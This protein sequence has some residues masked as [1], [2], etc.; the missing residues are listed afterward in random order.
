MTK[1]WSEMSL[2]SEFRKPYNHINCLSAAS[3]ISDFFYLRDQRLPFPWRHSTDQMKT[4]KLL[5]KNM[6]DLMFM[7]ENTTL[8]LLKYTFIME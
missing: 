7:L 1:M 8:K 4:L 5:Y 2:T 6:E 3:F